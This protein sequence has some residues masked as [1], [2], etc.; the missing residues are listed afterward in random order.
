[1]FSI[2][3]AGRELQQKI[4]IYK[5]ILRLTSSMYKNFSAILTDSRLLKLVTRVHDSLP[6]CDTLSKMD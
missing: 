2:H 6:L 1:M 3:S 5:I 4:T